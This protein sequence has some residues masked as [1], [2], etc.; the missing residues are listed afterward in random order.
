[1]KTTTRIKEI[2]PDPLV[3]LGRRVYREA[4]S[5]ILLTEIGRRRA[6]RASHDPKDRTLLSRVSPRASPLEN[7]CQHGWERYFAVGLDALRCIDAVVDQEGI[8]PKR[9]LDLPSGWG[10]VAR[11]L[12]VRYPDADLVAC[13]IVY[14]GPLFCA[15]RFGALP[16]QSSG[17]FRTLALPG[18]FDVIWVGSLFTHMDP[19]H[20]EGLLSLAARTLSPD[21]VLVATTMGDAV[22]ER[23][24]NGNLAPKVA[25]AMADYGRDGFGFFP[26]TSALTTDPDEWSALE[27]TRY[28][29]AWVSDEWMESAAERAGLRSIYFVS[30]DWVGYHDVHGFRLAAD[31]A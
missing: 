1:V 25:A 14:D 28:G 15:R 26:N 20:A 11:F 8:E 10:R 29:V 16:V 27:S 5:S 18:P 17:D 31:R 19:D 23:E 21:G 4:S 22:V 7:M 9:I 3:P 30:Q 12:R 2:L 13:D 6:L 24:K